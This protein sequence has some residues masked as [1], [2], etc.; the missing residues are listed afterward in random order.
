MIGLAAATLAPFAA[1]AGRSADLARDAALGFQPTVEAGALIVRSLEDGS[2]AAAAGLR[3]GDA[4]LAVGGARF[5]RP[6]D[7]A[8]LLGRLDGG[9][10]TA[11]RVRRGE[12]ES[13]VRFAPPPAPFGELD[14]FDLD[15]GAVATQDGAR[16]RTIIA[17][18]EGFT[19]KRPAIFLAQWVSCGSVERWLT[20]PR[21]N[22]LA[23]LA[24]DLG[25][26]I[27]LA[28]RASDGDSEGPAC[29][30]LG[31][32][33]EVA[34][35]VAALKALARS[36]GVDRK[37]IFVYGSSLGST[38]A[39]L[40]AEAFTKDGGKIAGI[41]VQGGG[42]LTYFERM[43]NFDRIYLERRPDA[44]KPEDLQDELN[45]RVLFH[46]DYLIKGRSP[47]DIAKDGPE[48]AAARADIRG[49]GEGEHYGRPYRWHQEA[50]RRNFLGAWAEIDA[51]VLVVFNEYD[52]FET[53]HGHRL[54]AETVNR[55]RPGTATYVKQ[56]GLDHSN[57]RFPSAAA[58]YADEGGVREVE[59][60][61]ATLKAWLERQLAG[62][63]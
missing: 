54:I 57:W 42:A 10:E 52:Q 11:L 44:V 56:M 12:A 29:H 1:A 31:Y 46:A 32:D 37:K 60:L 40:I 2:A 17:R 13:E 22:E 19:G 4:I 39:P 58:A 35:Y 25:I 28:E 53:E 18:P 14:G 62:G 59:T 24:R 49:L 16:L 63:A 45:R 50:A 20:S 9:V 8:A 5:G 23:P 47:D 55:L 21:G 27:L 61:G 26:V 48:M 38:T 51:P 6:D 15:Y 41:A 3:E 33:Q 34:H 36:E 30:E 7:G 43:L